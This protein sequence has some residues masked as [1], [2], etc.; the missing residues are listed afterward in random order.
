MAKI[1]YVLPDNKIQEELTSMIAECIPLLKE[2]DKLK[3]NEYQ[4]EY[5]N[6]VIIP[7]NFR[8]PVYIEKK[9]LP[10]DKDL[11]TLHLEMEKLY[12]KIY[13][14]AFVRWLNNNQDFLKAKNKLAKKELV[15][16]DMPT[17]KNLDDYHK[18]ILLET[19]CLNIFNYIFTHCNT[20]KTRAIVTA[21]QL[22]DVQKLAKK[23]KNKLSTDRESYIFKTPLK[24]IHL[25]ELLDE[26]ANIKPHEINIIH[27]KKSHN[28]VIRQVLIQ[29]LIQNIINIGW[30]KLTDTAI[31]DIVI[32]ICNIIYKADRTYVIK[33]VKKINSAQRLYVG[34]QQHYIAKLVQ[35]LR[36]LG[37]VIP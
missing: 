5:G 28:M 16:L 4:L 2:L 10:I 8:G 15:V 34:D 1:N 14:C 11:Q 30:H 25:V 26:L 20:I 32:G 37:V 31:A 24:Q 9:E 6:D 3:E 13:K 35:D 21:S 19:T 12:K 27:S 7:G 33:M 36:I 18:L 29:K 22:K 17:E 23:I